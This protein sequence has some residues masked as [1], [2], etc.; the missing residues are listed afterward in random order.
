MANCGNVILNNVSEF[1]KSSNHIF[2]IVYL[3]CFFGFL[4]NILCMEIDCT[5]LRSHFVEY[6]LYL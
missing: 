5:W 4:C 3:V 1:L 2:V 6:F